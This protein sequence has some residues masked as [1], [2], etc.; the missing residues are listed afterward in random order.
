MRKSKLISIGICIIS[1]FYGFFLASNFG[2]FSLEY[3]GYGG[4]YI[5]SVGL[6]IHLG[7]NL[8]KEDT[9]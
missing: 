3:L 1:F 5:L 2:L 9:K 7:L 4:I 8:E 6:G